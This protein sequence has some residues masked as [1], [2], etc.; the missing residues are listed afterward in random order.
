MNQETD[1]KQN[2][3]RENNLIKNNKKILNIAIDVDDVLFDYLENFLKYVN[4]LKG[5]S[6]S[7]E[8]MTSFFFEKVSGFDREETINLHNS[9][10][11]SENFNE[12]L[13]LEGSLESIDFLNKE[14]HN[15]FIITS[16]SRDME[17]LTKEWINRHFPKKFTEILFSNHVFMHNK[18]IS[19]KD[20][21]L[22]Y[23]IDIILEDSTHYAKECSESGINVILFDNPWNTNLKENKNIHRVNHWEEIPKKVK[24]IQ[25]Q[26][27]IKRDINKSVK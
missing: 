12:I 5:T 24:E 27:E 11:F 7:K 22:K 21:C 2:T 26:E 6:F 14:G 13:P 19:K 17:D 3:E 15:L 18:G 25:E 23:D 8:D 1:K 9:F 10:H 20:F 16:R 4:N